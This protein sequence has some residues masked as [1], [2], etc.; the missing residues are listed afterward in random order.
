LPIGTKDNAYGKWSP[1]WEGSYRITR[2]VPSNAYFYEKLEGEEFNKHYKKYYPNI[3]LMPKLADWIFHRAFI[4]DMR[5]YCLQNKNGATMT[6]PKE[7]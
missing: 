4:A 3:W 2:C 6:Q 1:N 7:R 5:G